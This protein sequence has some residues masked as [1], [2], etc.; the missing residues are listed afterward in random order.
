MFQI[1]LVM[2][3][4]ADSEHFDKDSDPTEI[5]K[6]EEKNLDGLLLLKNEYH[7]IIIFLMTL[8]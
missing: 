8:Y 6:F 1:F 2:T 4:V 5:G 3:R 7:K